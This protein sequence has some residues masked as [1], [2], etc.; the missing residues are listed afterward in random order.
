MK[1]DGDLP[2]LLLHSKQDFDW[3]C[4]KLDA[5]SKYCHLHN[6]SP[7]DFPCCVLSVYGTDRN[8]PD[9][10]T[11][12]FVYPQEIACGSCGHKTLAWPKQAE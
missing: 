1:I 6:G 11:H 8:G 3:H 5:D 12:S 9:Y 2:G 7:L 10:Y 4:K